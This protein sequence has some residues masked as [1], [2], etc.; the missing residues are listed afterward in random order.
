MVFDP[1]VFIDAIEQAAEDAVKSGLAQVVDRAK[2]KAPV[3]RIFKG[4]RKI[5]FRGAVG[6]Q[7]LQL[8]ETRGPAFRYAERA[9]TA[10]GFLH[11]GRAFASPAFRAIES[12]G[13]GANEYRGSEFQSR[14]KVPAGERTLPL[15]RE[16][17]IAARGRPNSRQPVIRVEG[18][19][20]VTGN[21]RELSEPGKLAMGTIYARVN[22]R[23]ARGDLAS[24]LT[25]RGRYEVAK[26]RAANPETGEIGGALRDSIRSEGPF[27][28]RGEVYGF[29][30]AAAF[31]EKGFNYAYAQ[32][33]GTGHNRPQPFLRPA[34]RE[35]KD[36]IVNLQ[37][38]AFSTA[39]RNAHSTRS[40]FK[41]FRRVLKVEVDIIGF[42][43]LDQ[44][45]GPV[46]TGEG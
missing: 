19:G 7:Q 1:Q 43:R 9:G 12:S 14:V 36:Q 23:T 5:K 31:N 15:A 17:R 45:L 40:D 26:G 22:G 13:R 46:V 27:V 38:N 6:V 24:A 29:V 25:A 35:L 16:D 32:E 33:V 2:H 30:R 41:G 21:F 39:L 28:T 37:R 10:V 11:S 18:L 4:D 8:N 3:R 20:R 34:L 42:E 44:G